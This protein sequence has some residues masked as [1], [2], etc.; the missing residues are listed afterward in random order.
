MTALLDAIPSDGDLDGAEEWLR[1]LLDDSERLL[2]LTRDEWKE[3]VRVANWVPERRHG[4]YCNYE[5]L[6]KRARKKAKAQAAVMSIP[7][8]EMMHLGVRGTYDQALVRAV[9]KIIGKRWLAVPRLY[10]LKPTQQVFRGGEPDAEVRRPDEQLT[11]FVGIPPDRPKGITTSI[12]CSRE[13]SALLKLH[14]MIAW[15]ANLTLELEEYFRR[16]ATFVWEAAE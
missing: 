5:H 11:N 15:E 14:D 2:R 10:Q 13:Q 3:A 7:V 4:Y 6:L 1:V 16:T 8:S 9:D 12:M